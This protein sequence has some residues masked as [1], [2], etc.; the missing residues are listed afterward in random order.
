MAQTLA[1]MAGEA[2]PSAFHSSE[3]FIAFDDGEESGEA[4]GA[5][6]ESAPASPGP[7]RNG[8]SRGRNGA[9]VAKTNGKKRKVNEVA[10]DGEGKSKRDQRRELARGTPWCVDVDFERCLTPTDV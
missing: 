7:H 2:G 1:V 6:E 8:S 10:G 4:A 5:E 3:D 9:T